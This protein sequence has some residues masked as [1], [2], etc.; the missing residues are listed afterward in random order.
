MMELKD[1]ERSKA[2]CVVPSPGLLRTGVW[3]QGA[4]RGK[5]HW[6]CPLQTTLPVVALALGKELESGS[7]SLI[8]SVHQ[9]KE[10]SSYS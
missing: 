5:A 10:V 1:L 6:C 9:V 7:L 3:R 2:P 4:G 8:N